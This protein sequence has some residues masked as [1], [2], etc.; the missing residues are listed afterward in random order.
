MSALDPV[1]RRKVNEAHAAATAEYARRL[2]FFCRPDCKAEFV[3]NPERYVDEM[4]ARIASRT[5]PR[6]TPST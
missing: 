2:Y 3:R 4:D 1:C 6:S 5:W